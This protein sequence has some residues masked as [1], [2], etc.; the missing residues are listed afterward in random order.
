MKFEKINILVLRFSSLGDILLT[1]SAI[2]TL[3]REFPQANI[4]FATH[5]RFAEILEN[6]PYI[7][8]IVVLKNEQSM[9]SFILS[10]RRMSPTH[11]LDLHNKL[12]SK[13]IRFFL[14]CPTVVW[15]HRTFF[16]LLPLPMKYKS[17]KARTFFA[18]RFLIAT[19]IL[20]QKIKKNQKNKKELKQSQSK[21]GLIQ[22]FPKKEKIRFAKLLLKKDK[23]DINKQ[24]IGIAMGTAWET[25]RWPIEY[26]VKLIHL[27]HHNASGRV[28]II[29]IGTAKERELARVIQE[30][31]SKESTIKKEILIV[32]FCGLDLGLSAALISLCDVFICNDSGPLHIARAQGIPTLAIFGSTD[33]QMFD[34]HLHKLAY[35]RSL[36]CSPC[37][38]NGRPACPLGH[39]KCMRELRPEKVYELLFPLLKA[40]SKKKVSLTSY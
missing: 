39:F 16:D 15:K 8:K 1:S 20:I 14:R 9:F 28:Q 37:G 10:L 26:F 31:V 5:E 27:I 18:S 29:L 34:L 23:I 12:R 32:D 13:V 35:L 3:A 2:E 30:N 36:P 17:Y 19:N 24:I 6:N 25:K 21:I 38:F 7:T 40:K 33:P 4:I 22:Y 11:V